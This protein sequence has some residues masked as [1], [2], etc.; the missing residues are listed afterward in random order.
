[1]LYVA[2]LLAWYYL[3]KPYRIGVYDG[4][5]R[6]V[7]QPTAIQVVLMPPLLHQLMVVTFPDGTEFP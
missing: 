7:Y 1:M 4:G 3:N 6:L 5:H 2:L